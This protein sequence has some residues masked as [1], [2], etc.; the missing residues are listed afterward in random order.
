MH[1]GEAVTALQKNLFVMGMLHVGPG[2]F[3]RSDGMYDH[4]TWKAVRR[5]QVCAL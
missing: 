2:Y 3:K 5:Y 1:A 4:K